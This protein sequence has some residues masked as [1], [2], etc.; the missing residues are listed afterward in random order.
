MFYI[1]VVLAT[2][3]IDAKNEILSKHEP[4]SKEKNLEQDQLLFKD[5]VKLIKCLNHSLANFK[6][7]NLT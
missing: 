6:S 7:K 3:T 5:K 2:L 1:G 4:S